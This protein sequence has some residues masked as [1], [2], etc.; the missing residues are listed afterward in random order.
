MISLE[1]VLKSKLIHLENA[2]FFPPF[3]YNCVMFVNLSVYR[4][5]HD[6]AQFPSQIYVVFSFSRTNLHLE[7]V[8]LSH[9]QSHS[10]VACW[11]PSTEVLCQDTAGSSQTCL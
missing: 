4:I 3:S 7:L 2:L 9:P 1:D 6:K 10:A 11:I 8:N 5:G